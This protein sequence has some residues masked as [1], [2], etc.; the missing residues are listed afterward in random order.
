MKR[1]W[2][3]IRELLLQIEALET[4]HHFYPQQ[5]AGHTA[6]SVSYHIHLMCQANLIECSQHH[7]WNGAPVSIANGL[8]LTGHDLLDGIREDSLWEAKKAY[9]QAR[10]GGIT[11]EGLKNAPT[12]DSMLYAA[13]R[14]ADEGLNG[15]VY[16]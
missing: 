10:A 7:P 2:E 14:G 11:Y 9:L 13:G 6:E 5:V 8:T 4:G 12:A 1:D 16:N 3:L 15:H